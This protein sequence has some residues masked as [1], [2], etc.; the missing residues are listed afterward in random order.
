M[1]RTITCLMI[2]LFCAPSIFAQAKRGKRSAIPIVKSEAKGQK[3]A[4]TVRDDLVPN[5]T[6]VVVG[7]G[8]FGLGEVK[9][10]DGEVLGYRPTNG[11]VVVFDDELNLIF[12]WD[13]CV[14]CGGFFSRFAGTKKVRG[15][16]AL[17]IEVYGTRSDPLM[18]GGGRAKPTA[19]VYLPTV[20]LYFDG[21]Q[22]RFAKMPQ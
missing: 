2:V 18:E 12:K 8:S 17:M 5:R 1:K 9:S 15:H 20:P 4:V 14:A 10:I 6:V 19:P 7:C 22:F 13:A 16:N 11:G 3:C 21:R